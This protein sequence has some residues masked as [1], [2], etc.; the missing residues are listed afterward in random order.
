METP[1]I[2]RR[3][4]LKTAAS[5]TPALLVAASCSSDDTV[6]DGN[7][8][9]LDGDNKA[10]VNREV[11]DFWNAKDINVADQI[12]SPDLVTHSPNV[13][14]DG[15]IDSFKKQ[16]IEDFKAFP[17]LYITIDDLV[18]EGDKVVKFWTLHGTHK[19]EW[20]GIPATGKKVVVTGMEIFR[21]KNEKVVENWVVMDLLGMLEQ[22]GVIPPLDED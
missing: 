11:E 1:H 18:A 20:I 16:S 7:D 13:P 17:D 14:Q 12:F 22:L 6:S 19:E 4:F 9:P 15:N 10:V 2:I 8:T 5:L 21:I 3:D